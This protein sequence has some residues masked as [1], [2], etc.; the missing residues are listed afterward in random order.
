[1]KK[2]TILVFSFWMSISAHAVETPFEKVIVTAQKYEF[3]SPEQFGVAWYSNDNTQDNVD[4]EIVYPAQNDLANVE[5]ILNTVEKSKAE[6]YSATL[7]CLDAKC[8]NFTINVRKLKAPFKGAATIHR[9]FA[10]NANINLKWNG[11]KEIDWN[12][13]KN[14]SIESPTRLEQILFLT[15]LFNVK[16]TSLEIINV[17]RRCSYQIS[18]NLDLMN[19]KISPPSEFSSLNKINV[20]FNNLGNLERLGKSTILMGGYQFFDSNGGQ[21]SA[22]SSRLKKV[23]LSTGSLKIE[24]IFNSS[25]DEYEGNLSLDVNWKKDLIGLT[26]L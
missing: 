26:C 9:F 6:D 1:M 19:P 25:T 17:G 14:G 8:E 12:D 3:T 23:N 11:I 24:R 4:F 16:E 5:F 21:A 7:I 10:S 20:F 2:Y 22:Q 13:W 15:N 18:S